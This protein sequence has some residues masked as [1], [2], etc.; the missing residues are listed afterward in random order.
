MTMETLNAK[1]RTKMVIR[2][3]TAAGKTS[4]GVGEK[5]VWEIGCVCTCVHACV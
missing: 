4:T 2:A 5:Y 3:V 1:P